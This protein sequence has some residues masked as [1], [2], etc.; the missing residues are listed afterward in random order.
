VRFCLFVC[1]F[2]CLFYFVCGGR[3][4][5]REQIWGDWMKEEISGTGMY[6]A[7]FT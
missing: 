4:K 5:D 1:L 6:G 7:K 3:C 2:V